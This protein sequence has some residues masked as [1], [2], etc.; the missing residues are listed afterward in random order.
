MKWWCSETCLRC[1]D[2]FYLVVVAFFFFCFFVSPAALTPQGVSS[3]LSAL[4]RLT[5]ANTYNARK[6]PA[7]MPPP[8]RPDPLTLDGIYAA[9]TSMETSYEVKAYHLV[10]LSTVAFHPAVK[11]FLFEGPYSSAVSAEGGRA[12]AAEIEGIALAADVNGGMGRLEA[13]LMQHTAN[14]QRRES[15]MKSIAFFLAQRNNAICQ[16]CRWETVSL[17]GELCRMESAHRTAPTSAP[18]QLEAR[19]NA[20]AKLNLEFLAQLPWFQ[21]AIDAIIPSKG[22]HDDGNLTDSSRS[23][24]ALS[25]SRAVLR[26]RLQEARGNS[27]AGQ[28]TEAEDEDVIIALRDIRGALPQVRRDAGD[29]AAAAVVSWTAENLEQAHDLMFVDGSTTMLHLIP[30]VSRSTDRVCG[31]CRQ[32]SKEAAALLRC[33]NC[34][35]V[36]YCSPECQKLHWAAAHRTPCRAYKERCDA[37]LQQH[38]AAN[39]R[40]RGGGGGGKGKK[41]DVVILEVPLEPSL[42]FETRRYLYDRRDESFAGVDFFDYFMKYTVRGT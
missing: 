30:C 26:R 15:L 37:I 39:G 16:E 42:F 23:E 40:R 20:Y 13:V 10:A 6:M 25:S 12:A 33:S 3:T 31:Q 7:E 19:L 1:T 5:D 28:A 32:P 35:A 29:P 11:R 22:S 4:D 14:R 24:S 21:L 8:P 41:G 2:S 18:G 17:L 34:K 9:L 36:Y 27:G 38:Y